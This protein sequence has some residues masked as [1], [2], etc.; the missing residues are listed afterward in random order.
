MSLK[1]KNN[2]V[3]LSLIS[4]TL[5]VLRKKACLLI[6][7]KK[8]K[9]SN[10]EKDAAKNIDA[11]KSAA[12]EAEKVAGAIKG[13]FTTALA[14]QAKIIGAQAEAAAIAARKAY[15]DAKKDAQQIED[16]YKNI[17]V[18]IY[19]QSQVIAPA[20]NAISSVD[21]S[22]KK[23]KGLVDNMIAIQNHNNDAENE[24]RKFKIQVEAVVKEIKNTNDAISDAANKIQVVRKTVADTNDLFLKAKA[25]DKLTDFGLK[26]SELEQKIVDQVLV[27]VLVFSDLAK[28]KRR[29]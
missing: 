5:I 19:E 3:L 27:E 8:L 18:P 25:E 20:Q 22:Y 17:V 2:T 6:L 21:I 26:V 1:L 4:P 28:L 13:K 11:A 14:W 7:Q 24:A 15:D 16:D 29:G 23:A 9:V 10:F 12:E